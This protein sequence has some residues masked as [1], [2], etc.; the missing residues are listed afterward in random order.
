MFAG[1]EVPRTEL[2]SLIAEALLRERTFRPS[3]RSGAIGTRAATSPRRSSSVALVRG[4]A[5]QASVAR[6][7][8]L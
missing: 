3:G 8:K 1:M 7:V 2:D 5:L 6:L 4:Q